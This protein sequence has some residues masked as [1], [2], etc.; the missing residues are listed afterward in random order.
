MKKAV[1][2]YAHNPSLDSTV[3]ESSRHVVGKVIDFIAA[4]FTETIAKRIVSIILIAAGIDDLRV[5]ELTGLCN[6]S[7]RVLRKD[8]QSGDVRDELF[9]LAGGR[10]RKS[11]LVGIEERILNEVESNSY[12]SQQEIADMVL[13]KYGI[14]VHRSVI[15][16]I[17]KKTASSG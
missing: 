17:L 6:K 4:L 1:N 7:V 11:K 13:E 15:S 16:R 8:I 14:K 9:S 2:I 10:G 5:T 12:H 3:F